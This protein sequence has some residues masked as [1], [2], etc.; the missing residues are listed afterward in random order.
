M[1]FLKNIFYVLTFAVFFW[2]CNEDDGPA[3]MDSNEA[4]AK[5][6]QII[7][8]TVTSTE[9]DSSGVANEWEVTVVTDGGA[10]VE[11]EFDQATGQLVEIEGDQ[12]PFDYEINPGQG[13][14]SFSQAKDI[15]L[16]AAAGEI[17]SWELEKDASGNWIYEFTLINDGQTE[18]V[19]I[20]AVTG[21]VL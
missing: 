15:A 4:A 10:E 13:L 9:L 2:A 21:T 18:S 20:D 1:N 6:L 11:V 3:V 8:G 7:S 5:A 12:G 16:N 17:E 19:E 14:I